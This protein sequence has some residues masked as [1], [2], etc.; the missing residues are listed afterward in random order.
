[1]DWLYILF[2]IL[3][4][5]LIAITVQRYWKGWPSRL[6]DKIEKLDK[7]LEDSCPVK[8]SEGGLSHEEKEATG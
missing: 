1:M 4:L 5:V 3:T 6:E 2:F 7:R 8:L